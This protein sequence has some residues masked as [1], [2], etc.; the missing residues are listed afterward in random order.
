MAEPAAKQGRRRSNIGQ[1]LEFLSG[2][3]SRKHPAVRH[4]HP[5]G[6]ITTDHT[7]FSHCQAMKC[8][9]A[10]AFDRYGNFVDP[11]AERAA[12][13]RRHS[14][15][16]STCKDCVET[17]ARSAGSL[18]A[19]S[20]ARSSLEDPLRFFPWEDEFQSLEIQEAVF[21]KW[22]FSLIVVLVLNLVGLFAAPIGSTPEHCD[23]D[24]GSR[25]RL[26]KIFFYSPTIIAAGLSYWLLQFVQS[27]ERNRLQSMYPRLAMCW[28]MLLYGASVY[29]GLQRELVR[30]WGGEGRTSIEGKCG[31]A[32]HISV[33]VNYAAWRLPTRTC[34][35]SN[36]LKTLEEWP[37][38]F[39][40][41]CD[42]M[43]VDSTFA[44]CLEVLYVF[45]WLRCSWK[46]AA[47]GA[48][49]SGLGLA[50]FGLATGFN[51]RH[52]VY[53]LLLHSSVG[54]VASFLCY[55]GKQERREEFA[56]IKHTN[57][58]AMQSRQLLHTLIPP[59]VL[60]NF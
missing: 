12:R 25:S 16:F 29:I 13:D 49:L 55:I 7:A 35:D 33:A 17:L 43:L 38:A 5:D 58:A 52:L 60:V 10:H 30:I 22:V 45:I 24:W 54:C 32:A 27:L 44:R 19:S 53:S 51:G 21:E 46:T 18:S 28:F 48:V 37:F 1:W 6:N 9:T 8:P 2:R 4:V 3:S 40:W 11:S 14:S 23:T 56:Q 31:Q 36:P 15:V 20:A 50:F 26:W 39:G 57:L 34:T 42:S 41:G 47:T 59:N